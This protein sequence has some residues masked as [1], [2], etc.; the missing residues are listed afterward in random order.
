VG[1]DYCAGVGNGWAFKRVVK[2]PGTSNPFVST[3]C[4]KDV[5][6]IHSHPEQKR[7]T[8]KAVGNLR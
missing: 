5:G 2:A 7:E 4:L 6:L 8:D 3:G 1:G